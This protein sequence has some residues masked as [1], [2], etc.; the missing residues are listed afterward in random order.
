MGTL[1]L[2][3]FQQGLLRIADS[4]GRRKGNFALAHNPTFESKDP[5]ILAAGCHQVIKSNG[6]FIVTIGLDKEKLTRLR[7]TCNALLGPD[8]G[9]GT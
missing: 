8:A 9:G 4:I 7:D 5:F 2:E 6:G 1:L 3:T